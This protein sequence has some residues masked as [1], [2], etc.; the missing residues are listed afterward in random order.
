[1]DTLFCNESLSMLIMENLQDEYDLIC[2]SEINKTCNNTAN[3]VLK[4]YKN[5]YLEKVEHELKEHLDEYD[6]LLFDCKQPGMMYYRLIDCYQKLSEIDE[7]ITNYMSVL[8]I[9]EYYNIYEVVDEK[10]TELMCWENEEMYK[11][12]VDFDLLETY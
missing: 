7:F 1:M 4:K 9:L 8:H 2:F 10:K 5:N 11:I 12:A 6:E 3:C